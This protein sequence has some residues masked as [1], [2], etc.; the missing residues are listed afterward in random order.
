MRKVLYS[1]QHCSRASRPGRP[2]RNAPD[3]FTIDETSSSG[4]YTN[5]AR[6][7]RATANQ[8]QDFCD[9]ETSEDTIIPES[10]SSCRFPRR[11]NGCAKDDS[12][13]DAADPVLPRSSRRSSQADLLNQDPLHS[14]TRRDGYAW[15]TWRT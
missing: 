15:S 4:P 3:G 1:P 14:P 7:P 6:Q 8:A 9:G 5:T 10:V 13:Y 12:S 11:P 2:A